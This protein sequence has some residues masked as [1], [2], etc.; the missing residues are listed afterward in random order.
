MP[1]V[2]VLYW[3]SKC[4]TYVNWTNWSLIK[5]VFENKQVY[6]P[7]CFELS[8][9]IEMKHFKAPI[10][11]IVLAPLIISQIKAIQL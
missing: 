10:A 1:I 9:C 2:V 8:M 4:V 11:V 5:C 3:I 6:A 7:K